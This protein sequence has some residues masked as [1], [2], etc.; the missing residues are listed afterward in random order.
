MVVCI[1]RAI[2]D[3]KLDGRTQMGCY[4]EAFDG[5]H[6]AAEA[7]RLLDEKLAALTDEQKIELVAS[8]GYWGDPSRAHSRIQKAGATSMHEIS[9]TYV[10]HPQST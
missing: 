8:D 7:Q 1:W 9:Q 3:E 10:T 6:V 2:S 4:E 5:L